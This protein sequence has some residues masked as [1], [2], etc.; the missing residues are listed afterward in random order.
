M[1]WSDILDIAIE[2]YETHPN[3]DPATVRFTDLHNW[4]NRGE[5]TTGVNVR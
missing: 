4:V 2:L 3:I 1:K 5:I